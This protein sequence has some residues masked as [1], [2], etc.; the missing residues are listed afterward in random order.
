MHPEMS[1]DPN[2]SPLLMMPPLKVSKG[3]TISLRGKKTKQKSFVL[4]MFSPIYKLSPRTFA[5]ASVSSPYGFAFQ[6]PVGCCVRN[7]T[8]PMRQAEKGMT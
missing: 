7:G 3:D 4:K 6:S 1:K 5:L 2:H 8:R